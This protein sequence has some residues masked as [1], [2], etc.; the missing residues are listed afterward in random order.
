MRELSPEEIAAQ[1]PLNPQ[2]FEHALEA[3]QQI[4]PTDSVVRNLRL[5]VYLFFSFDLVGSTALKSMPPNDN[6]HWVEVIRYFYSLCTQTLEGLGV[7]GAVVWKYV[8]D[9]VLFYQRVEHARWIETTVSAVFRSLDAIRLE[10]ENRYDGIAGF[11]S[12]KALAWLAPIRSY[13]KDLPANTEE[14]FSRLS[15]IIKTDDTIIPGPK[16]GE[17]DF[18]GP[19]IDAGFRLN[20]FARRLQ[21]VVSPALAY[22]LLSCNHRLN[23]MRIVEA[24][25]LKGVAEGKLL[26]GI[27]YN[28]N[29]DNIQKAFPYDERFSDELVRRVCLN[30]TEPI[31]VLEEVRSRITSGRHFFEKDVL[32]EIIAVASAE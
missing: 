15:A 27:W 2:E 24:A 6:W 25:A 5:D 13:V 3:V 26:P 1:E 11:I 7:S 31:T 20:V 23:D 17:K 21:L 14:K 4:E 28:E 29:W 9:E 18:L 16:E 19:H 10:L 30:Q 12:V 8:G 22:Y 32:E